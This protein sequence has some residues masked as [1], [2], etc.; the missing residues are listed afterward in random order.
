MNEGFY[1]A[2][3][4]RYLGS[5]ELI[6]TRRSQYIPFVEPFKNIYHNGKI[7]DIGCGRGEW[8]SLMKEMGMEVLGVD[9]DDG[10]LQG[11]REL[12][13]PAEKGD[14]VEFLK[15]LESESRVVI[16]AF[17]VV[18]HITFDE[19][20]SVVIE[21]LRILK[22]GGLLIMETPNPENIVVATSNFYLDPTHKRPIPSQLLS[23]LPEYYGFKRVKVLRLQESA[24]LLN[25]QLPTLMN[26]F[27]GVSP[28]YAVVAQ[29]YATA[30]EMKLFD[31]AF[32]KDYGLTL[33]ALAQR[34]DEKFFKPK[35]SNL[36]LS[37]LRNTKFWIV[38]R[39]IKKRLQIIFDLNVRY[40]KNKK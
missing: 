2:F 37:K 4:E 9:L 23:F 40:S 34:Y 16:S 39:S 36:I 25:N 27:S 21:A 30:K 35:L 5:R 19:L 32:E 14:A 6:K 29:K 33:E 38:L 13:L 24:S 17:H 1:R 3:E 28:D 12:S 15:T 8:L 10:M 22:P 7:F 20:R 26:V 18:E 31:K 11:C